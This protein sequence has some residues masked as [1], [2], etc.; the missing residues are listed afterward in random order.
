MIFRLWD[1]PAGEVIEY[2]REGEC[3]RCGDCC[4]ALIS[5]KVQ[6]ETA[7]KLNGRWFGQ[8]TTGRGKW[9]E[10]EGDGRR[11]F[12]SEAEVIFPVDADMVCPKLAT[13]STC[14]VRAYRPTICRAW[15]MVPDHLKP[16]E[17]CSYTF[18][19]VGRWPIPAQADEVPELVTPYEIAAISI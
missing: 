11:Y 13:D 1:Y 6:Q 7:A 10:A 12:I 16:F 14:M 2:E 15:P 3:N 19:E 18:R 17:R 4:R 9:A 8:T 5:F